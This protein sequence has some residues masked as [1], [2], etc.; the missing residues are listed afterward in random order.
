MLEKSPPSLDVSHLSVFTATLALAFLVARFVRLP[1]AWE[2]TARLPGLTFSFRLTTGGIVAFLIA[3]L[4]LGGTLGMLHRH[5]L[6]RSGMYPPRELLPHTV[7]PTVSA[8]GVEA[9]LQR[10]PPTPLFGG[11]LALGMA[12]ILSVLLAEFVAVN[13]EDRRYPWAATMLNALGFLALF[14]LAY[15]L[16]VAGWRLAYATPVLGLI[17]SLVVLRALHLQAPG[18]WRPVEAT[19]VTMTA[20]HPA[21]AWRYLPLDA[22]HYA[23]LVV[24][25]TYATTRL[26]AGMSEGRT[27]R[28]VLPESLISL[29]LMLAIGLWI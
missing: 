19:L 27:L 8:W 12:L 9:L 14:L 18:R 13:P 28:E 20:L 22:L 26:A 3:L 15:A 24:G 16:H 5:P 11:A 2:T 7:I 1:V 21:A 29:G 23:I 25:I 4:S 17:I 10:F 6:V